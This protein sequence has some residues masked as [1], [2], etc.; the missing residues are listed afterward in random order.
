[1]LHAHY[2]ES[3]QPAVG[4]SLN[5]VLDEHPSASALIVHNDGSVAAL[6]MV[7]HQRGV[8]VP[9]DLSVTSL[10]SQ[11]FGRAFSLPYTAVETSPRELG[12]LAVRQLVSRIQDPDRAGPHRV[13]F[14]PPT[15]TDRGSTA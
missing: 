15:L 11:E 12:R 14:L 6:P 8:R 3:R 1:M 9:E 13:R 7:L 4:E 2:G 5:A 10:Y